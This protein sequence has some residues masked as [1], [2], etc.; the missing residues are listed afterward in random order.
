MKTIKTIILILIV[1]LSIYGQDFKT[2][3]KQYEKECNTFVNDTI[4]QFGEVNFK[5]IP[6]KDKKGKILHYVIS[7]KDTVWRKPL[8]NDFK[9]EM[10]TYSGDIVFSGQMF[11]SSTIALSNVNFGTT[12]IPSQIMVRRKHVCRIKKRKVEPFSTHFWEWIKTK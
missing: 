7:A 9:Y 8:C 10:Q 3:V 1:N 5:H 2:L 11:D 12:Q 6:V 4:N